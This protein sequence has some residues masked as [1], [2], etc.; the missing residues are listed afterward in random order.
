MDDKLTTLSNYTSLL[1]RS[2]ILIIRIIREVSHC[3]ETFLFFTA[4]TGEEKHEQVKQM[5]EWMSYKSLIAPRKTDYPLNSTKQS[6][7]LPELISI[8]AQRMGSKVSGSSGH[9][10]PLDNPIILNVSQPE[11]LISE[12]HSV[13]TRLDAGPSSSNNHQLDFEDDAFPLE[14]ESEITGGVKPPAC[15]QNGRHYCTF[16]EDYPIKIVTEVTRY[17]KWP[18]EKLFRDLRNQVMPKLANDNYGGLVC[19]SITRVVRPGWARNTN[20]RWLVIINTD[21]YQQYVTEVVC[22]HGRGS[23]CN[24]V[25]PC[26]HATCK[27]RYNTQ[28]LLVIDPWNPYKGPFLSEFLFPSC[29]ICHISG[30]QEPISHTSSIPF[31]VKFEGPY[32]ND[33][34]SEE[35]KSEL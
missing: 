11:P 21:N 4:K 18:L 19:D 28:K 35:D 30:D 23:R 34:D 3:S 22:R 13:A 14:N 27:Q 7:A 10:Q 15:G 31:K 17:Y 33:L 9:V 16:K 1:P 20:G 29:C 26:Y 5:S 6:E 25:A 32:K 2:I 24:F 12:Q 8:V